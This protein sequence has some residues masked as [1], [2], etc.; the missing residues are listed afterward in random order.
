V[1][2]Y[3]GFGTL[4][5]VPP[6]GCWRRRIGG[7]QPA[8]G[9]RRFEDFEIRRPN[10]KRLQDQGPTLAVNSNLTP[11]TARVPFSSGEVLE[12]GVA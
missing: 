10:G 5:N 8:T 7:G 12:L 11:E 3:A 4:E 2:G 1:G 9:F 6:V